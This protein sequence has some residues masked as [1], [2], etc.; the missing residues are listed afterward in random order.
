MKYKAQAKVCKKFDILHELPA[1]SYL[2]SFMT[3]LEH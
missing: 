1:N 3:D 2:L